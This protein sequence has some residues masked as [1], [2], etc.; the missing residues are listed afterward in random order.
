MPPTKTCPQCSSTETL[1]RKRYGDW[2]CGECDHTWADAAPGDATEA[3]ADPAA[4]APLAVAV[5]ISYGRTDAS[6]LVTRLKSDLEAAGCEPV[7]LDAEMIKGGETWPAR[8]EAGIRGSQAL[9]AVMTPHALREDSI[10]HDEVALAAREGKQI[11]PVR[12][13]RDLAVRPSLLLVRRSWVDFTGD[14]EEAL[15]RLVQAL[16]G[17]EAG[18]AHPLNTVSGQRPL[19]FSLDIAQHTH[20]F[21]GRDWLVHELDSWLASDT[22]RALVLVGEPGIGKSAFAAHLAKRDDAATVHFCST[23]NSDTLAPLA[24]VASLVAALSARLPAFGAEVARRHPEEPRDDAVSAFRQLVVEPAWA[25]EAPAIHH[26]VIVDALDEAATREGETLV[27]LLATHAQA[28]PAWLR[29]IATSRPASDVTARLK[30]LSPIELR[31]E[32][33]E[34][35]DDLDAYLHHRLREM[36]SV[37]AADRQGVV[38]SLAGKAA[39]NFLYAKMTMDALAGSQLSANDVTALPPGLDAFYSLAFARLFP[40]PEA[41]RSEIVPVLG[42]L[43]VAFAPV[44]FDVLEQA[45]GQSAGSLNLRLSKLRP[46]L[47]ADG[48]GDE[49]TYTLFHRSLGEWLTNRD[50]AGTHWCDPRIAHHAMATGLNVDPASDPYAVRCLPRHLL[51]LKRYQAVVQLLTDP[52]FLEAALNLD[53]FEV[54]RLWAALGKVDLYAGP[55]YEALIDSPGLRASVL[56]PLIALLHDL[57]ALD[58]AMRASGRRLKIA[59]AEDDARGLSVALGN[60]AVILRSRG[61]LDEAEQLLRDQ[62]RECRAAGDLAGLQATLGNRAAVLTELRAPSLAAAL[63]REQE[64]ICRELNELPGMAASLGNQGLIRK[65]ERDNDG[66]LALHKEEEAICRRLGDLSGLS[67]SLGNQ[68]VVLRRMGRYD[69]ALKL[70]EE[71]ERACRELGDLAGLSRCLGNEAPVLRSLE[72]PA[73]ALVLLRERERICRVLE[74]ERG[75]A[76]SMGGQ[77]V[78]LQDQGDLDAAMALHKEEERICRALDDELGLAMS[79]GGQAVILQDRGDLDAAMA[80]HKEEERICRELGDRVGLRASLGCQIQILGARGER[81]A[82]MALLGEHVHLDWELGYPKARWRLVQGQD[83]LGSTMARHKEEERRCREVGDRRGLAASLGSQA[84]I[85]RAKGEDVAAMILLK[86]E[87]RVFRELADPGGLARSLGHQA[88]ILRA[89]GELE[90]ALR[91]LKEEESICRQIPDEARRSDSLINQARI[92]IDLGELEPA[93]ALLKEQEAICRRLGDRAGLSSSLGCQAV[94]LRSLG[95]L[96]AS[97]TLLEEQERICHALGDMRGLL[98]ALEGQA[99][100]LRERGDRCGERELMGYVSQLRD[101]RVLATASQDS[102]ALQFRSERDAEGEG[103]R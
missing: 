33:Q 36:G 26:L 45:T 78:I 39:G 69:E 5:F 47:R 1:Y 43:A 93:M 44:P 25:I 19:D 67:R 3:E 103:A 75:V 46:Y 10:C 55:A 52:G 54:R 53:T 90:A 29:V 18:L 102:P 14:Y 49:A 20:G 74:D 89:G 9:L 91:A 31:A 6:A 68:S 11:V 96:D 50:L 22:G 83:E 58:G 65:A 100:I 76:M 92:L 80:L 56:T 24:F 8:I 61:R 13:D 7:W 60:R 34:N 77:A 12:V 94:V 85:L 72:R 95:D 2:L 98:L 59:H 86:Q 73:D 97:M 42:V 41:Y 84:T 82:A 66:A 28:L 15:E 99:S 48:T 16:R 21:V 38:E 23:G 51:A 71:Q 27:D 17:D 70:L 79:M 40:D 64:R 37:P 101:Y 81:G 30:A 4:P 88:L 32:R 35:L 63:L 57:G 87:E 62:E